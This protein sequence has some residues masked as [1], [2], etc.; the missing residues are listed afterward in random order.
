MRIL[1]WLLVALALPTAAAAVDHVILIS[2][3]GLRADLLSDLMANDVDGDYASFQRFVD[4]GATTFNARTDYTYTNTLPN[5]TCMMTGRPVS[6]PEGQPDATHH[7]YTRNVDPLPTDT[8]HNQGNPA[9]S[10]VASAFDVAHDHGLETALYASKSKFVIFEQS[11]DAANGATDLTGPDD[12]PDKIDTYENGSSAE[13]HAALL[14]DL[15]AAPARFSF[16]H[17]RDPDS[18]GHASTWGSAA[19]NASVKTVS[20]YVG[21]ILDA[22]QATPQLRGRTVI[23]LTTDHGGTGYGHTS[24][25]DWR[26]YTIPFF[27]WGAGVYPGVDLYALNL[28]VRLDPG[29]GRPSYNDPPPIRNGESGNLAM[30]LLG[31]PSVPGSTIN[32]GQDLAVTSPATAVDGT[33][34]WSLAQLRASPNPFG[35]Q[36]EL[37]FELARAGDV[38]IRIFDASGRL[39]RVLRATPMDRG[40]HTAVWNGR[41]DSGRSVAR[42]VYYCHFETGGATETRK[43]VFAR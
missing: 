5:H 10:Y 22:V 7:G 18:A 36:T 23:I 9:V 24:A 8:L 19:W 1:I 34:G 27:V 26:N 39:T 13:I 38:R 30:D 17:Y 6:Q 12:G 40:T 35:A 37:T 42:G 16:V 28:A 11:Y 29:A 32:A 31:L 3:D 33:T 21:D 43:L 41:D 14:E 20:G 4:E 15:A 25:S 2:V